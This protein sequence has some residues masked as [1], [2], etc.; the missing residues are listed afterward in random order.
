MLV[1]SQ[2][3]EAIILNFRGTIG[4]AE[5]NEETSKKSKNFLQKSILLAFYNI[6][7][8]FPGGGTVHK[9]WY[10]GF[11]TIWNGGL[12]DAFFKAKNKYPNYEL[13]VT[14]FSMGGS[15]AA[16]AAPYISQLGYFD[17]TQIKLVSFGEMRVGHADFAD[18]FS[19]LVPFAYRVYHNRDMSAHVIPTSAGYKHHKNEVIEHIFYSFYFIF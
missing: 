13:W 2:D 7:T 1:A 16:L 11:T 17:K 12:R 3:D 15:L 14:G 18:R 9:F 19:D 8:A 6:T 4:S 10:N 5:F